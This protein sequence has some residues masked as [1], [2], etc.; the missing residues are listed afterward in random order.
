MTKLLQVMGLS[1]GAVCLLFLA[2]WSFYG[3][4]AADA[5]GVELAFR[6]DR[7]QLADR[8]FFG[9]SDRHDSVTARVPDSGI[10][11]TAF[12]QATAEVDGEP[13]ESPSAPERRMA[14]E[15]MIRSRFPKLDSDELAGW[16]DSY[17]DIPLGELRELLDQKAML[18]PTS[19]SRSAVFA[20]VA[21]LLDSHANSQSDFYTQAKKIVKSNLLHVT[22]PGYRRQ[23]ILTQL[24]GIDAKVDVSSIQLMAPSFDYSPAALVQSESPLHVAMVL[25]RDRHAM[26]RLEPGCVLTRCGAFERLDDGRLGLKIGERS[27][28]LFG[29][30]KIPEDALDVRIDRTGRITHRTDGNKNAREL[31]GQ[32]QAAIIDDLSLLRSSNGVFF[33]LA[34]ELI[35]RHVRMSPKIEFDSP[36]LELSNVDPVEEAETLARIIKL[37]E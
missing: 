9:A 22:T 10:V 20:E 28:A 19:P 21:E 3:P 32:I 35:D 37:S 6:D 13:N 18:S 29:D 24:R 23:R 8:H 25:N 30:I 36:A 26:F 33:S 15:D 11:L 14:V 7:S 31:L 17:V 27:L 16:V 1:T 5:N 2:R 12:A 34:P 4:T